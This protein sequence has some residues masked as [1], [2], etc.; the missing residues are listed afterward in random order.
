M[1]GRSVPLNPMQIEVLAWVRDR[2][3]AGVYED[4][5]HRISARALHNR[6]LVTVKGRGD[7][8]TA[9]LTD[10]GTY[11]LDHSDY[12]SPSANSPVTDEESPPTPAKDGPTPPPPARPAPRRRE[13]SQ[14][15]VRKQGPVDQLMVS[16]SESGEHQILVPYADEARYRQLAGSAKRFGRIPEGMRL[17]FDR[18]RIDGETM[19][20]IA[21]EPLPAWQS[22]VLDPVTV[23]RQLRDPSDVVREFFDSET[24]PVADE[25]RKRA[26]RILDALVTGARERDMTVTALP[27]QLIRRDGYATGGPRRDEVQFSV[28]GDDFRL[29]F[30]QATLQKA[31]EPTEREIARARRGH[32]FPDFDDIPDEHLGITLEGHGRTFWASSWKDSD[33]HLLEDDLAQ[34]L[35]EIRLRHG[36]LLRQRDDERERQDQRKQEWEIARERALVMYQQQFVVDAMQ[37]QAAKWAEATGLRR[38][39]EAIRAVAVR[40]ED[41]DQERAV[42]WAARV[43]ERAERLDPLPAAALL[44]EIPAPSPEQL[45]PFMG[46]WSAYGPHR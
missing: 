33:E 37:S 24:F 7:S 45:S 41:E 11:Y 10:D 14:Q 29:W 19:L 35:E 27:N 22:A 34:I 28:G 4:W 26:L 18:Q 31:H 15:K 40:M 32:L 39:A 25:V 9:S 38:Y 20:R 30:T 6:G 46:S 12:P 8:W 21:L 44:P 17:S 2:C 13:K 5:S 23:A 3:A 43:E 42:A 16:L 1:G 36:D